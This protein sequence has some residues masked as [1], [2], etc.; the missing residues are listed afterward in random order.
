MTEEDAFRLGMSWSDPGSNPMADVQEY[1]RRWASDEYRRQC[2][3]V[4]VLLAQAIGLYGNPWHITRLHT[5]YQDGCRPSVASTLTG[6]RFG[7]IPP[8]R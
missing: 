1:L 2:L 5:V 7:T 4:E 6:A 8:P 3:E